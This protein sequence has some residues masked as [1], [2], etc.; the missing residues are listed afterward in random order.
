MANTR[1]SSTTI[2]PSTPKRTGKYHSCSA[3]RL[4][5]PWILK[6]LAP[7]LLHFKL[8]DGPLTLSRFDGDGET[9]RLGFG[10]GRTVEGPYTQ[11]FYAWMEVNNWPRWER[12]LIEGPY[13]H[14]SSCVYDHCADVLKEAA[15]YIPG[16][17]AEELG[18]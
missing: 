1:S 9:Y 10:E 8:K 12:Q 11:E 15:R 6:G 4:D 2:F 5:R 13:I 14:H 17:T 3:V 16:L 18:S 7:G